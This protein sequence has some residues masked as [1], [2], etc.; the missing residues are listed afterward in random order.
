MQ[1]MIW[2]SKQENLALM[3]AK[4]KGTDQLAYPH[5][6]IS[7]SVICSLKSILSELA[8]CKISIFKL[9]CVAE[10]ARLSLT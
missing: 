10:Q 1:T 6:L 3:H 8:I 7:N 2:T 4:N 9:V 5:S